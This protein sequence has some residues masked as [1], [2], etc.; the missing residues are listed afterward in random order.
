M[1]QRFQVNQ[2]G[3]NVDSPSIVSHCNATLSS[4]FNCTSRQDS[5]VHP[6]VP[7]I[8]SA[9]KRPITFRCTCASSRWVGCKMS[10]PS[11]AVIAMPRCCLRLYLKT[12]YSNSLLHRYTSPGEIQDPYVSISCIR[13]HP[14]TSSSNCTELSPGCYVHTVG[15]ESIAVLMSS[16][17]S[18]AVMLECNCLLIHLV[19]LCLLL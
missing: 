2:V 15:S 3:C 16:V 12:R 1:H 9:S 5:K 19:S 18:Q 11:I 6:D 4:L 8:A 17:A 13:E 7:P 10:L 14:I